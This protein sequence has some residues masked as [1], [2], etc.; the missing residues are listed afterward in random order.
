MT[1]GT[2]L[3][4]ANRSLGKV[5]GIAAASAALIV[6][7]VAIPAQAAGP[8]VGDD[9]S[10]RS[11]SYVPEATPIWK[12]QLLAFE[13]KRIAGTMSA[14]DVDDWN[15]IVDAH[16]MG[17][18][19]RLAPLG[20]SDISPMSTFVTR[21]LVVTQKPQLKTYY[22]GPASA[23][24]VVLS[25]HNVG[26]PTA[27]DLDGQSLSQAHLAQATYTNANSGST[28]WVDHDMTRGL[29]NWLVSGNTLYVQYTPSS[30][31]DLETHV[32]VDINVNQMIASD[33][34][35]V[36]G[37]A[38]YNHHPNKTIY[39]WTTIR[40]YDNSGATIHFQDPAA[41]TTVLG[42]DWDSVVA[43]FS[44]SSTNTYTFMTHNVTRGIAW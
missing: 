26:W 27:S 44:M 33:M 32:M 43:T 11:G 13:G 22:C 31:S 5:L 8:L 25:W 38:H 19:A 12:T 18:S 1:V 15:A 42:A 3:P 36:I 40:G 4:Q 7:G 34:S 39:H 29:N 37:G 21:D 35:E 2:S 41:N 30:A 14:S 20:T 28:D 9:G 6:L 17:A 16:R 23:Q 10:L 24:S